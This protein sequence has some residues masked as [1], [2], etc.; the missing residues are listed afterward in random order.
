MALLFIGPKDVYTFT[1]RKFTDSY[2]L[3]ESSDVTHMY[4]ISPVRDYQLLMGGN[5][6]RTSSRYA[7]LH[8]HKLPASDGQHLSAYGFYMCILSPV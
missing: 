8:M 6:R 4:I 1:C 5:D 3:Y 2:V 7:H